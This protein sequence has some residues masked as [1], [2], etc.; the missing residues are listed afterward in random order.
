MKETEF[1]ILFKSIREAA[2]VSL[3]VL[4]EGT[5]LSAPFLHDLEKGNRNPTER[6]ADAL[7]EFYSLDATQQ[8]ELYDSI[9]HSTDNLPFDVIRFLKSN[10]DELDRVIN[11]MNAKNSEKTKQFIKKDYV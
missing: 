10:P 4:S 2:D 5:N 1:T 3:R 8:R 7:V 11:N 6:V 9:A